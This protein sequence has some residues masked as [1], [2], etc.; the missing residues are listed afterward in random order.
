MGLIDETTSVLSRLAPK[1]WEKL[2]KQH[3]GGLDISK[4]K[5]HLAAELQRPLIGINRA[6]PGFE[7]LAPM[8]IRGIEPGVPSLSLLYHAFASPDVHP[9][10]STAPTDS[11]Y[12]TLEELDIIENFIFS[13]ARRKLS[14]FRNPVIAVFACQY[15]TRAHAPHQM[16]ADL[17]FSRTGVARVG[18]ES[19]CYSG[20]GR[21][22]N[23][24]PVGGDRG[25]AV[26]PARYV[27]Y[28]A[29][30]GAPSPEHAI[31]RSVPQVD[32]QLTFVMPVHK[33]F[34]GDECLVAEDG[35]SLRIPSLQF[36]EV[37]I[38][39]KL[40][41]IH[42]QS[43]DNPGWVPPLPAFNL[44]TAPFIRNSK[45]AKDLVQLTNIGSFALIKPIPN[46]LVLVP[47]QQV[48]GNS[49]PVRF[50][51]PQEDDS[52]RFWSSLNLPPASGRA[53]PEYANIRLEISKTRSGSW[54]QQ[55][56]NDISSPPPSGKDSFEKKISLGGYEAAH[57]V[58]GTCDGA[59]AVKPISVVPLETLP[60]Y[61]LVTAVDY[62]PQVEQ[63][64]VIEWLEKRQQ[65]PIG[66]SNPNLVFPQGG[67]QPLSDGRFRAGDA[68]LEVSNATPNSQLPDPITPNRFAF[69]I[70]EAANLTAT[71]VVS[72]A[73]RGAS[74]GQRMN[75]FGASSW[76]PD[77]ASDYFAPGW[78][79]SLHVIAGRSTYVAYGLGS[80]FPE[81]SKLCAALNSFWPAVAPDSSRTYGL[82]PAGSLLF[83]S[84]PLLDSELGYHPKHPRVLAGE[85]AESLG[86]DGDHGPFFETK[87][88][89]EVVNASNPIRAD[90]TFSAL[91][92]QLG[93]SGLDLID[94]S[95]LLRRIEELIFC[96]EKILRRGGIS[97]LNAWLVSVE[98][99]KDW[100]RW[101]STVWPRANK[102]LSESGYIFVFAEV[103]QST[104]K[105][106]SNPPYR[107]S[108]ITK[109]KVQVQLSA[110]LA[111]L[112]TD[113]N[114]FKKVVR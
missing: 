58:D 79:V 51:V 106:A 43:P 82:R 39:E 88:K 7:E 17:A 86:W 100:N 65:K 64:T 3:G 18:T 83:T 62:F 29:E 105:N 34:R 40:A 50:K 63:A 55:N 42:R 53:A 6:H 38:S 114:M 101:S 44:N 8:A 113:A 68:T 109:R 94:A 89:K 47:Q 1:G 30:Y 31:L 33:L 46:R 16:H 4:P 13:L 52:N 84:I 112:K 5:S 99:V 108:F 25:F 90:Q 98:K 22:F 70:L 54:R 59:I 95:E 71:A 28:I 24:S 73:A 77:A 41:R 78:D 37:H 74:P 14:S 103:D 32:K 10:T 80:P 85:V 111:F 48:G 27:A 93:F 19:E 81:D 87:N 23:P 12:P 2:F 67:P 102:A 107:V 15:R 56:L 60:A 69:S 72:L 35:N 49:E 104:R 96:R 36:A 97:P 75:S 110:K 9:L 57:F 91:N 26:L 11:D 45:T 20:P 66:L 92:G 76:L 21:G 61:S